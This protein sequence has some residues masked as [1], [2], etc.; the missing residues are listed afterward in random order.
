MYDGAH[1]LVGFSVE[2][3]WSSYLTLLKGKQQFPITPG[4]AAASAKFVYEYQFGRLF[5]QTGLGLGY[6]RIATSVADSV[7]VKN[8]NMI[9]PFD[10]AKF[11]IKLNFYDRTD[12]SEQYFAQLPINFGYYLVGKG[13]I[14]YI[15]LGAQINYAIPV[16]GGNT[17]KATGTS[18]ALFEDYIGVFEE[19]DNHGF[20]K[21]VPMEYKSNKPINTNID[22]AGHI[23]GGYEFNTFQAIREYRINRSDNTDCRIRFSAFADISMRNLNPKLNKPFYVLLKGATEEENYTEEQVEAETDPGKLNALYEFSSFEMNH[24]FETSRVSNYWIGNLTVGVRFTVLFSMQ[25]KEHCILCDPW[26]H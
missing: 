12:I 23:E 11:G 24:V 9:D 16:L 14:G 3:G 20:R 1:H 13:G 7:T 4:G 6:H 26:R 17:I 25:A 8:M 19:M 15:M 5:F 22:V 10:N 2:G 18:S 21:D